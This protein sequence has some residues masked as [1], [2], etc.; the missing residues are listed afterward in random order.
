MVMDY[1]SLLFIGHG[2]HC[3][4]TCCRANSGGHMGAH[5]IV[6]WFLF[7]GITVYL[8]ERSY[9][10]LTFIHVSHHCMSHANGDDDVSNLQTFD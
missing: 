4:L 3:V 2:W 7:V 1:G 6:C 10:V 9:F 8:S 5:C